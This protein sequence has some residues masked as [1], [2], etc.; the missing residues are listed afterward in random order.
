MQSPNHRASVDADSAAP[1]FD[2]PLQS[3]DEAADSAAL[4]AEA[5]LNVM[6]EETEEQTRYLATEELEA[7]RGGIIDVNP[8]A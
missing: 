8:E 3:V 1:S 7:V 2:Q 4:A 5:G 6:P